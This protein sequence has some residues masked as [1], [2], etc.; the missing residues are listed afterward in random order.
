MASE[1]ILCGEA[2]LFPAVTLLKLQR[3]EE[4]SFKR[5]K[6]FIVG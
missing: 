6:N 4:L 3:S 2:K 1:A 5:I